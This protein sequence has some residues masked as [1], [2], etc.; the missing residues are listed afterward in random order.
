MHKAIIA[1]AAI[2]VALVAS[3]VNAADMPVKAARVVAE[4]APTWTGWNFGLS[5]GARFADITGTSLS[6]GGFPVPAPLL[7]SQSYDST[8]FRFG[9]YL[10]YDWQFAPKWVFGLEGD[11]AWGDAKKHVDALQGIAASNTGSYSEVRQT[12]DAGLRARLGYLMDQ[13]GWPI[14]G[15]VQWHHRD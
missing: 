12:W 10:G 11:F 13:R 7:A 14:T 6:F 8:A 9:G 2:A 1:G 5:A 3:P 15:G 4:P